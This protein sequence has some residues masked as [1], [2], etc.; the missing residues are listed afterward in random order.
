MLVA[1]VEGIGSLTCVT[2]T[3]AL[4]HRTPERIERVE[5]DVFWK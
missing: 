5:P 2:L 3:G 1:S 4:V